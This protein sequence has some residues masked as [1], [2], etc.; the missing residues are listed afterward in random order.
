MQV[1]VRINE[2]GALRNGRFAF[3]D[4]YTLVTELRMRPVN[5][6]PEVCTLDVDAACRAAQLLTAPVECASASTCVPGGT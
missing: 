4:R 3:T 6:L 2:Q 5:P 1:Q